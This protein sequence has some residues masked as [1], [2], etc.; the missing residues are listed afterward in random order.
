[1]R[2][3][4]ISQVGQ[5]REQKAQKVVENLAVKYHR[6][7]PSGRELWTVIGSDTDFLVYSGNPDGP[8]EAER[9]RPYCSCDDYH[10]RVLGG[11]IPECYH[12]IA[13][14]RAREE[15]RFSTTV[16]SDEEYRSFVR[17]LV[18]DIFSVIS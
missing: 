13:L 8:E 14:R 3:N 4:E 15:N 7:E 10:F 12:L 2:D 17:G 11:Q 1:M 6:F 16:F 18:K 5:N 9:L